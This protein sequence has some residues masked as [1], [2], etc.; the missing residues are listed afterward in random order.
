MATAILI[1]GAFFLHRYRALMTESTQHNPE[2]V[3]SMMM[4]WALSHLNQNDERRDL[5]RIFY[6]DCP[7]LD[8]KVTLPISNTPF[9]FAETHEAQFRHGL[10]DELRR[11]RKLALRLGYLAD[12]GQWT[13]KPTV[14]RALLRGERQYNSLRD[15][16]FAYDVRQKGVDIRIGQDIASLAYKKLADQIV[17]FAGDADFVPAAKLARREGI[18]FVLDPMWKSIP[19]ELFEH[20]DGLRSTCPR[21]IR[22]GVGIGPANTLLPYPPNTSSYPPIS[23]I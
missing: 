17:L 7:P 21:P 3:A 12:T 11:K 6:Y 23:S 14:M 15:E 19:P 20:I 10:F 13:I 1:D 5:Y 8:K 2:D 22:D 18:D 4:R 16:D 9:D